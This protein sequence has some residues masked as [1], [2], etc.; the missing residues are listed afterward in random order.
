MP[1][2]PRGLQNYLTEY[3]DRIVELVNKNL[4]IISVLDV[5]HKNVE[6]KTLNELKK[7]S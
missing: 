3:H 6:R 1:W 5:N 4:D 2:H 7:A